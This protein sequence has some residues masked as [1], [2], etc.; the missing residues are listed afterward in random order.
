VRRRPDDLGIVAVGDDQAGAIG[1]EIVAV[2]GREAE[3]GRHR[4]I[5]EVAIIEIVAPFAVA[6]QIGA[7]DLDLDDDQPALGVDRDHVGAPAVGQRHLANREHVAAEEQPGHA[8]GDI[9]R[10]E[11][12]VGEAEGRFG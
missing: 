3:A 12:R 1:A 6:E 2:E 9:L 11:R 8:A 10:G 5:E 4:P 7:R